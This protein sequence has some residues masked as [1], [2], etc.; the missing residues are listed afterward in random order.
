VTTFRHVLITT[1]DNIANFLSVLL[2][3]LIITNNEWN[4]WKKILMVVVAVV[5]AVAAGECK[6]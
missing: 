3:K 2:T 5:V 4:E 6:N 1:S